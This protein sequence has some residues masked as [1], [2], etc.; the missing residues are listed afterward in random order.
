MAGFAAARTDTRNGMWD[1]LELA[2]VYQTVSRA[3]V[4]CQD[5][6]QMQTGTWTDSLAR[7]RVPT[8]EMQN[9]LHTHTLS[10]VR[11]RPWTPSFPSA[12]SEQGAS[13]EGFSTDPRNL[14]GPMDDCV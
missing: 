14:R 4:K 7:C 12:R 11:G 13:P 6:S 2:L 1:W 3:C 10:E 5:H 8:Q 9:Y